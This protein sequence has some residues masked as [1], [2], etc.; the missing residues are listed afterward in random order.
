MRGVTLAK[1][2]RC[3]YDGTFC[4]LGDVRGNEKLFEDEGHRCWGQK[5]TRG[6][7]LNVLSAT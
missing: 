5:V 1:D 2:K 4:V 6:L 7:L 3:N